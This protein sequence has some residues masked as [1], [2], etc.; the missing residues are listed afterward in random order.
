[1][2]NSRGALTRPGRDYANFARPLRRL[3]RMPCVDGPGQPYMLII[4]LEDRSMRN[5]S[6]RLAA[7]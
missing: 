4:V 6:L 3:R 5:S 2:R 7:N 1:M